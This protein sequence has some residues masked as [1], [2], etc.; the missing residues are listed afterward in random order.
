MGTVRSGSKLVVGS[1][2]G[3]PYLFS[4]DQYGLHSDQFPGHP[5]CVNALIHIADNVV[6]TGREDGNVRAVHCLSLST[7]SIL[8][9]A[10]Q[11]MPSCS[12]WYSEPD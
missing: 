7:E 11:I 10:G 6:I 3:P 8:S 2:I 1:G 9:V 12:T 4:K 5:D